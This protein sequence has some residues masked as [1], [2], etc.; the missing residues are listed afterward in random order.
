MVFHALGT[1]VL[2]CVLF[3]FLSIPFRVYPSRDVPVQ[4]RYTYRWA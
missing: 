3:S 1:A 2:T 4:S